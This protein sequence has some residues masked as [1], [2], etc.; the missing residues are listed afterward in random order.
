MLGEFDLTESPP[1][2]KGNPDIEVTYDIDAKVIFNDT[3]RE[4]PSGSDQTITPN[5]TD[6]LSEEEIQEI[7]SRNAD[8]ELPGA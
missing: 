7:I 1:P 8:V 2:P 5:T 3:S 4:H 6:T